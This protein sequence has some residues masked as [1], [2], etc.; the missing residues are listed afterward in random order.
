MTIQ[1][2]GHIESTTMAQAAPGKFAVTIY[3]EGAVCAER[4]TLYIP[5]EQA[6]EWTAGR[7]V[8]FTVHAFDIP[9]I[10]KQP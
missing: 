1:F 5:N 2:N 3:G 8:Q 4:I 9:N 6:K 10:G 7:S